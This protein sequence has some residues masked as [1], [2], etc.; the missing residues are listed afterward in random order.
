MIMEAEGVEQQRAPAI[1]LG[2]NATTK[3]TNKKRKSSTDPAAKVCWTDERKKLFVHAMLNETARGVFTDTGFKSDSWTRILAEFRRMSGCDYNKQQLQ[4]QHAIFKKKYTTFTSLKDNSGFGWDPI[5]LLPTAPPDVWDRYLVKHPTAKEFRD[6]TLL[7]YDELH[8]IFTGKVATGRFARASIREYDRHD[9]GGEENEED[10]NEDDEERD[11]GVPDVAGEDVDD[12]REE[13]EHTPIGAPAALAN[14]PA[15]GFITPA[16]GAPA[17]AV[18]PP[19]SQ[20]QR[21]GAVLPPRRVAR[22]RSHEDVVVALGKIISNQE[23]KSSLTQALELFTTKYSADLDVRSRL[24]VK[25][26]FASNMAQAEMFLELSE[27]ERQ[28]FIDSSLLV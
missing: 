28:E 4:S 3:K 24:R 8:S 11:D 14:A 1:V 21:R 10:H 23:K 6:K 13:A 18:V 12:N 16:A 25:A 9:S 27:E 2:D 7:F 5:A 17:P 26:L 20:S 19:L 15:A 22:K